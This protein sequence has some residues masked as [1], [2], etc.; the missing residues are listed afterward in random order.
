[1][2]T[3]ADLRRVVS[4][5][6]GLDNT[7]GSDEQLL[8]DGWASEA[9]LQILLATHCRVTLATVSLIAGVKDYELPTGI[10]AINKVINASGE[11]LER[12]SPEAIYDLRRASASAPSSVYRYAVDGANLL[13]V[14]PTP[15]AADT[16]TLYHVPRPTA[17]ESGGDDPSQPDF[18]G[19]PAEHHK[20]IEYWMLAEGADYDENRAKDQGD[21]YRKLF[22]AECRKIRRA[23][24]HRGARTMS[25]ARVGRRGRFPTVPS[26]DI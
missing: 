21:G 1:V 9:V 14:W 16:L 11:P 2:A 10:I 20:A 7:D 23:L 4:G 19:I 25:P 26:Q 24:R 3:L 8:M 12:V 17:L 15:A 5:K 22:E 18:G 13:M 6:L